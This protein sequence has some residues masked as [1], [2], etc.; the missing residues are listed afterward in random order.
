MASKRLSPSAQLLRRSRLFSLPPVLARPPEYQKG[1]MTNF[2]SDTATLR[3]PTHATIETPPSSL[4]RGD[5]GLKRPLP[6]KSTTNT[7]TPLVRVKEIDNID[8]ITNYESAAEHTLTLRKWQE[9]NMPIQTAQSVSQYFQ[10]TIRLRERPYNVFDV[11]EKTSKAPMDSQQTAPKRW[12]F[13]GPWLGGMNNVEFERFVEKEIKARRAEF[14]QYLWDWILRQRLNEARSRALNEGKD[15]DEESITLS[16]KEFR[17]E[18]VRLRKERLT[19]TRVVWE[20]LDLPG[21]L[22][23]KEGDHDLSP[24]VTHPSAGLSYL[25]TRSHIH[26]HPLLGPQAEGPPL[27]SRVLRRTLKA[28]DGTSSGRGATLVGMGGVAAQTPAG[29]GW[30]QGSHSTFEGHGGERGWYQPL[31]ASIDSRGRVDLRV[32]EASQEATAVWE[33]EYPRAS[34]NEKKQEKDIHGHLRDDVGFDTIRKTRGG[35]V[36]PDESL[37]RQPRPRARI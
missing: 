10:E 16:E 28:K 3:Y 13:K 26:N 22:G 37:I 21:E 36:L 7:S 17:T 33:K 12:K 2:E 27:R 23:M 20:F 11:Y 24:P 14:R 9:L 30:K 8:H 32:K 25:R 1:V 4:A 6:L 29:L 34:A 19:L 5:W 18:I 31:I 35:D 15:F